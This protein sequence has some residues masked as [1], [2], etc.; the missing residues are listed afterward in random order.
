MELENLDLQT[1]NELQKHFEQHRQELL[2][3]EPDEL[4]RRLV[5]SKIEC[6]CSS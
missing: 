5:K 4:L 3:L 1:Q 6:L 2:N